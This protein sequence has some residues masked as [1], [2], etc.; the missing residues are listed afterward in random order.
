MPRQQLTLAMVASFC[1]I[2]SCRPREPL[3]SR[4]ARGDN[5]SRSRRECARYLSDASS[6]SKA[7]ARERG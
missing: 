2:Q 1:F 4:V 5:I 3:T 7:L 6:P